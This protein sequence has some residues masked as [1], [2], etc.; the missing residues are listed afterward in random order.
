MMKINITADII[1][2]KSIGNIEQGGMIR[3]Y[4]EQTIEFQKLIKM[5]NFNDNIRFIE[6]EYN[7][8]IKI[9]VDIFYGRISR[10]IAFNNYIGMLDKKIHL[11]MTV[12]E[13]L[14]IDN[15]FHCYA[16]G[17]LMS[18]N[19][20]GICLFFTENFD[21]DI[22]DLAPFLENKILGI[23]LISNLNEFGNDIYIDMYGQEYYD[24]IQ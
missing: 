7:N 21:A 23:G 4:L 6:Y 22:D 17:G 8:S 3:D 11:G 19:Y 2:A 14:E 16:T 10:I 5:S 12:K 9:T 18:V 20:L 13:I 1:P 15:S 24:I